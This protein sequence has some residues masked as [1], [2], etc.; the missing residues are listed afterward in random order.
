MY[1]LLSP[2]IVL[3]PQDLNLTLRASLLTVLRVVYVTAWFSQDH[4]FDP[5]YC[6]ARNNFR[7]VSVHDDRPNS[8]F[9]PCYQLRF[10]MQANLE[11]R[12]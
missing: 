1:K 3:E 11:L 7:I 8:F 5:P 12:L 4:G 10:A 6:R 9:G 2:L